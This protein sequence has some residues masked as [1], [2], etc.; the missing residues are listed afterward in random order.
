MPGKVNPVIPR[1]VNLVAYRVMG[2]DFTVTVAAHSG[3]LAAQR[4]R[5]G[6]RAL[7]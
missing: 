5:A 4:L 1:M 2:N 6:R 7:L 3:Q